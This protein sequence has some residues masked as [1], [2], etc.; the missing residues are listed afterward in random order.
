MEDFVAR[1]AVT[2]ADPR[3]TMPMT[4]PARVPAAVFLGRAEGEFGVV[5]RRSIEHG[6]AAAV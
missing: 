3:A 4:E 1:V 5:G 2:H 6:A